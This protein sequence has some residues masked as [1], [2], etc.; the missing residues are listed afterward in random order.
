[1]VMEEKEGGKGR[2]V[3]P[4]TYTKDVGRD[5]V[6]ARRPIRRAHHA[7]SVA[8]FLVGNLHAHARVREVLV[9]RRDEMF[10]SGRTGGV[11]VILGGRRCR[12]APEQEGHHAGLFRRWRHG[13]GILFS[14]RAAGVVVVLFEGHVGVVE[15]AMLWFDEGGRRACACACV[16]IVAVVAGI[17]LV[18]RGAV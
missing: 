12:F 5:Q 1:M 14:S 17:G 11:G 3:T 18:W 7:R 6:E 16:G 13:R 8:P 9:P 4:S 2:I 10:L 15:P